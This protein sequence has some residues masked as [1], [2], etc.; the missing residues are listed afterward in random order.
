MFKIL[1]HK[2]QRGFRYRNVVS[3]KIYIQ[4]LKNRSKNRN[5]TDMTSLLHTRKIKS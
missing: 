4:K 3:R 1:A 2:R 5:K